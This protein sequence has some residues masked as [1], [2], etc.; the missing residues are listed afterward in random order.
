LAGF[1]APHEFGPIV[2]LLYFVVLDGF[3]LTLG[4][5]ILKYHLYEIDFVINKT[6]VYGALAV[7]IALVYVVLVVG[8]GALVGTRGE[9]NLVLSLLATAIVAVAFEPLRQRLQRVANQLVYGHR[10]SPYEVLSEFSRRMAGVLSVDEVLPRMAAEAARGVNGS[11]SR[12]RVYVPGAEDQVVAWPPEDVARPFD[13]T[14]VVLHH[15]DPVG[16]I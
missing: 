16:E 4:L 15:G 11:R 2:Q 5:A 14:E 13:R 7:V 3:L 1:S 8:I 10:L 12:V 6:L 9:P